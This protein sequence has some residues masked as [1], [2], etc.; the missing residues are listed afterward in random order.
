MFVRVLLISD[1]YPP[2]VGGAT[3]LIQQLAHKLRS[4]GHTVAVATAWQAGA[5]EEDDDHGVAV[6]RVRD[7]TSRLSGVSADATRHT[8]PPWPDPE[9]IVRLRR[10]IAQ[11]RPDVID[12]YGWLSYSALAATTGLNLP[13]VVSIHDYGNGC[14]KRT[15]VY[16]DGSVCAGPGWRKCVSC[17]VD[18]YGVAK[19]LTATVGVLGGRRA[20]T[21]RA[22]AIIYNSGYTRNRIRQA[23]PG[24]AARADL[25]EATVAPVI[26][27]AGAADRPDDEVLATLPDQPFILYVG[28]LRLVKGLEVLLAAYRRLNEAPP[29]VLIGPRAPDTPDLTGRGITVIEGTTNATVLA[30]WDRALFGVAPSLLPEPFGIAVYEAMARGRTVIGTTPGGQ[31]EMIIDGSTGLLVPPGDVDALAAAMLTLNI[32]ASKRERLAAAAS[33]QAA[34]LGSDDL[35]DH[36]ERVYQAARARHRD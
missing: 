5:P 33:R 25:V 7:L 21:R 1:S 22:D 19:G 3:R 2:L 28:A 18:F 34:S 16:Q 23:L 6:F 26:S 36:I 24:L 12:S 4:R 35:V 11:V 31:A 8:P 9:A 13:V 20:L 32:D 27:S 14:P 30:A 29:L 17:A 15:Y 10:V